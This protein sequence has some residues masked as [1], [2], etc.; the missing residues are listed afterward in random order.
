VIFLYVALLPDPFGGP[1]HHPASP[2]LTASRTPDGDG[3][4][5]KEKHKVV[6][7]K[8]REKVP[9][10]IMSPPPRRTTGGPA[11]QPLIWPL[12][13]TGIPSTPLIECLSAPVGAVW[14]GRN[15]LTCACWGVVPFCPPR[16][17][18]DLLSELQNL[19]PNTDDSSKAN[20]TMNTVLQCAIDFL[21][22]RTA[23][24]KG[25]DDAAAN[26]VAG[27]NEID[28]AYRS[29][30]MMTSMGIAYTVRWGTRERWIGRYVDR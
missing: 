27:I 22:S 9:Y 24:S 12:S 29:G 3:P 21:T 25:G 26:D 23:A 2:T 5:R 13:S 18:K 30:F 1:R 8:R 7:Q 10:M 20:L 6:E 28:V 16:Q 14:K 19:L 11:I 17:T 4:D 15:H